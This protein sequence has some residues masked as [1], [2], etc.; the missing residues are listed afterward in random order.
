MIE[1]N[2]WNFTHHYRRTGS[3]T[4]S[5]EQTYLFMDSASGDPDVDAEWCNPVY[6]KVAHR[7]NGGFNVTFVDGHAEGQRYMPPDWTA[8]PWW[9]GDSSTYP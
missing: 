9:T 4:Q 6:G 7:H 5:H 3:I 1:Y 8:K 2:P